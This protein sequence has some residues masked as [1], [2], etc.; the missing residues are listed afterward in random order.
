MKEGGAYFNQDKLKK[1]F[2][3][4]LENGI[5][6]WEKLVEEFGAEESSKAEWSFLKKYFFY[7]YSL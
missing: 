1:Q 3:L 4:F 6:Q 7:L 2:S 5:F